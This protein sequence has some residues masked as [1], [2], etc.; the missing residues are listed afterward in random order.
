MP[1][2][3]YAEDV[4]LLMASAVEGILTKTVHALR[5]VRGI[6]AIVLGGSRATGTAGRG[7]DI[8][9]GVYYDEAFLDIAALRQ[10]GVLLDD[11]H[12]EN[13]VTDPGAWGPWINGGGWLKVRGIAVDL[14]YRDTRKVRAVVNDC[15][16]GKITIDYQCGHPFG[17]VSSIYMGE[18]VYCKLLYSGNSRVSDLKAR[19][20][21]FPEPYRR[22]AI[23]K[24]LWEC[25]FSLLCGRK[26]IAK[27]DV[28]Y[29][30]GSLYRCANCLIQVLYAV[31]RLYILNEKKQHGAP[32][33]AEGSVH[34]Q[35][36][37]RGYGRRVFRSEQGGGPD[38]F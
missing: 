23:A 25:E 38:G 8:D 36:F 3:L 34:A 4:R 27:G 33:R 1:E 11:E 16:Q 29:A 30:A 7:S 20:T 26:A 13:V 32:A 22:A 6:D 35:A 28:L 37:R 21:E 31:N 12:R 9:I 10:N 24:F 2:P 19:L 15:L 17:F 18:I 5:E 14:L